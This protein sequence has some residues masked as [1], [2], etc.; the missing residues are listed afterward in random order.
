MA[1]TKAK[2]SGKLSSGIGRMAR[3]KSV[4]RRTKMKIKRWQ[5]YAKE[6]T[7]ETRKGEVSRWNTTGLEQHIQMMETIVKK[8]K[9]L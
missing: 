5:R 3:A 9:T 2:S 1:K 6:I 4:I 7:N 8:G